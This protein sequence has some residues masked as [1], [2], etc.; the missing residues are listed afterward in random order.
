ME[1]TVARQA[2]DGW[3]ELVGTEIARLGLVD[4]SIYRSVS[5]LGEIGDSSLAYH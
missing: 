5:G 2:G 1:D 3:K 4:N